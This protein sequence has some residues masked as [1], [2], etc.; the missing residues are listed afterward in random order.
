MSAASAASSELGDGPS[1]CPSVESVEIELH[2]G[3]SLR[4]ICEC[5]G[6]EQQQ[7]QQQPNSDERIIRRQQQSHNPFARVHAPPAPKEVPERFLRA[8]KGDIME[9]RRR[10]DATLQWRKEHNIDD[11][12]FEPHPNFELIKEHYPH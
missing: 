10:Y 9:G 1:V 3:G 12:L 4:T 8:G 5:R 7:Q 6:G 11:I 2:K